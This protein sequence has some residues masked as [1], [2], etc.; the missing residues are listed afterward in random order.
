MTLKRSMIMIFLVS[1]VWVWSMDTPVANADYQECINAGEKKCVTKYLKCPEKEQ[2]ALIESAKWQGWS[3]KKRMKKLGEI[4]EICF[5]KLG[6]CTRAVQ[7]VCG[8]KWL[9]E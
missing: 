9:R 7:A 8:K 6:V 2:D 1:F 5:T 4:S 3:Y